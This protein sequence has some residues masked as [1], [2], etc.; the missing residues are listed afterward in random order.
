MSDP[1]PREFSPIQ[2]IVARIGPE[3]TARFLE[4]RPG[5]EYD[6]ALH[7]RP[8]QRMPSGVWS[9]W[10]LM[11]GRG[12]GKGRSAAEA[13]RDL[14][15]NHGYRR[16]RLFGATMG[17]VM[18]TMLESPH[19]GL[20]S[21]FPPEI[22]P[23]IKIR[24][25]RPQVYFH[26]G[27]VGLTYS[28]EKPEKSRGS[29]GDVLWADEF[30]A[31][32]NAQ[33][34][35][36]NALLGNRVGMHPKAILSTTPL[37]VEHVIDLVERAEGRPTKGIVRDPSIVIT[38]GSTFDN[39]SNLSEDFKQLLLRRYE[40]T[41]LGEQELY[42]QLLEDLEGALWTYRQ[43]EET[44]LAEAPPIVRCWVGV[45]PSAGEKKEND[46]QGIGAAALSEKGEL[47]W[48]E[49]ATV[50][51]SPDGWGCASVECAVRWDAQGVVVERNTGGDMARANIE[52]ARRKL[53]NDPSKPEEFRRKAAALRI[54]D[55]VARAGQAK[56]VRAAPV[57]AL[58]EQRRAHLVG[59]PS[60]WRRVQGECVHFT[61]RGYED[62]KSPNAVDA[63]VHA[64][65]KVLG[66][67]EPIV[68]LPRVAGVKAMGEKIDASKTID[69]GTQKA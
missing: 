33:E 55:V 48:L 39:I 20:L 45:D 35:L 38:G 68:V 67:G 40:G 25:N 50:K 21:V 19:G 8:S 13:V 24:Q 59:A 41:R 31:M 23:V 60:H 58:W 18:E 56:H 14:I 57:A 43:L 2:E 46:E 16:L 66:S 61:N 52:T 30:A 44:R 7:S 42:A 64:S 49:D 62:T 1:R 51:K 3:A 32:P 10:L 28:G 53:A 4:S 63:L 26:N 22:R 65:V 29:Q 5:W 9:I 15:C 17:D 11:A 12:Y 69:S 54:E 6:W 36:D 37:P 47:L 27:A 34:T